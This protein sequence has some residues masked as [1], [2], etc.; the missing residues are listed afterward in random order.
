MKVLVLVH[1]SCIPPLGA[2]PQKADWANW[3]TEF[4]V[5]KS[6]RR[7]GHQ[8]LFCGLD[9]DLKTLDHALNEFKPHVVFNLLEEFQGRAG[10]D[11]HVVSFLEMR[12]VP[13]TGCNPVGLLL[14][15]D[16]ALAKKIVQAEGL[17]TP[18]FVVVE[19]NR[20]VQ[21][22]RG[23]RY[24]LIVKSQSEEASMGISQES[25]VES[26]EALEQRVQ[27]MHEK[28]QTAALVEEYILG[29][30]LYVGVIGNKNLTV[31]PP[32]ELYFGE[33]KDKGHPIATRN[34][35]FNRSYCDKHGI[36]RGRSQGLSPF[37]QRKIENTA[38]DVY[39]ALKLTGY[40]RIDFRLTE[41]E[42]VYFLEANPNA[43]LAQGECLANAAHN[44]ELKY[45]AL[46]SKILSLALSYEI[47]A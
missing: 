31:L 32:W 12:G 3:K 4:Y 38:R 33:L 42:E 5:K 40:A 24:P 34:V 37:L 46:I 39:R 2:T 8:V 41:Q 18:A 28:I 16:K 45:D 9:Q 13:Y 14:G 25:I 27:F 11:A 22:P 17:H 44:S 6:L 30:E 26:F 7:L 15:R 43:E 29:R 36:R 23:I 10:F 20:R 21:L 1:P 35:K 47:A 19:R